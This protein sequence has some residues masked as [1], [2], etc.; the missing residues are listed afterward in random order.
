MFKNAKFIILSFSLLAYLSPIGAQQDSSRIRDLSEIYVY[1]AATTTRSY[2][3]NIIYTISKEDI[4]TMPVQNINELLDYLPGVDIRQRGSNGVQADIS[5]RGGTFDQ[6]LVLINGV[7][8][9]DPQTGHHNLDLPIDINMISRIEVLQ[10][11]A[12][13]LFGLSS[14]SG[15]I[16]I[17][18]DDNSNQKQITASI[19]GGDFG[20]FTPALS[21]TYQL[22]KWRFGGS[23]SHNQSTGYR[24]NTDFNFSN[25]FFQTFFDNNT[26]G[27][28]SMQAGIQIKDFGSNGFYSLAYPNQYEATKTGFASIEWTKRLNKIDLTASSFY[29]RHTDRFELFR[30][31]EGAPAWYTKHNYH[32]TNV[33]GANLKGKYWKK[34]SVTSAGIEVRNENIQSNVLGDALSHP[35]IVPGTNATDSIFYLYGKNRLN[36]NYFAEKAL[37]INRLSISLGVS[38][39]YNSMFKHNFSFGGNVSYNFMKNGNIFVRVH[40]SLRLPTFTDLYYKSSIQESNPNLDPEQ[41]LNS[42]LQID[43][44]RNKINTSLSGFYRIGENIIDWVKAPEDTKWKAMNHTRVD[45]MGFN[46]TISY[47]HNGW[48]KNSSLSYGFIH[49]EKESGH[50]ISKYALD[51]LKHKIVLN[52]EHAIYRYFGANWQLIYQSRAGNYINLNNELVH[53]QPFWLLDG[54][55]YWKKNN[56]NIF[57]EGSNLL[58]ISYYD[59]GGI[60][61]PKRW[62]KAGIVVKLDVK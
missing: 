58:N 35:I 57:M 46:A 15:A 21:G 28:F 51:Y 31:M 14:F 62:L 5:I 61:Q 25:L 8:I 10:G 30:D 36:F 55:I 32:V 42:E 13:S 9:T 33:V 11:T 16:N 7:N 12:V 40:R 41:S 44:S 17:I 1:T 29:R 2:R 26:V 20:L 27:Q 47:K 53:Y 45:A 43:W 23:V 3:D 54:R 50:M 4:V 19:S 60:A 37:F 34:N 22:N 59:Y 18:T 56:I 48:L 49:L 39:N 38:G 52:I 24:H 6:V